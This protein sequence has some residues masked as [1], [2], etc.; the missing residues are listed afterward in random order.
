MEGQ[1]DEIVAMHMRCC[2]AVASKG[3]FREAYNCQSALVQNFNKLLSSQKARSEAINKFSFQ[4]AFLRGITNFYGFIH[5]L[6]VFLQDDNWPLPMMY[7]VCLDLRVFASKA[8][9]GPVT[10]SIQ[11]RWI[12]TIIVK[13]AFLQTHKSMFVSIVFDPVG[14]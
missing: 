10:I 13:S 1:I 5:S 6:C 14:H 2:W 12:F 3:D 11:F 8:D 7:V 4:E 9:S